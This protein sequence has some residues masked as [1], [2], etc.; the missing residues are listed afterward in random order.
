ME[1]LQS[2]LHLNSED[3]AVGPP[4]PVP[5]KKNPPPKAVVRRGRLSRSTKTKAEA[6]HNFQRTDSVNLERLLPLPIPEEALDRCLQMLGSDD[7]WENLY[8]FQLELKCFC[9]LKN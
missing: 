1:K 9:G 6:T 3:F 2:S 8:I 7:W 4:Q 5:P